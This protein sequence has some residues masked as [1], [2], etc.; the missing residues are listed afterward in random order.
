MPEQRGV[1]RPQERTPRLAE[2]TI[3]GPVLTQLGDAI[4]AVQQTVP[5]EALPLQSAMVKFAGRRGLGSL[6]LAV[7]VKVIVNYGW[8]E[9]KWWTLE[10]G[11]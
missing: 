10:M 2:P 3:R 9:R 6:G 4:V 1:A 11:E 7:L 5:V 8:K